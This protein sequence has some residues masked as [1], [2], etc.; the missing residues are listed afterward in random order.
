M[1][2]HLTRCTPFLTLNSIMKRLE[3]LFAPAVALAI[4]A[5]LLKLAY[6]PPL[7]GSLL[8]VLLLAACYGYFRFFR[9]LRVPLVLF[10]LL[11]VAMEVDLLGNFFHM[12]GR[13][14]GPVQY[15]EF[16]HMMTSALTVPIFVWL[17]RG[18]ILRF[19]HRLPLGLVATLAVAISF[20]GAALYEIIEL[21][22]EKYFGG[23]R[24]WGPYDTPNDLQ[25]DLLGKI[26]GAVI[27]VLVLGRFFSA[28]STDLSQSDR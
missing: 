18:F 10:A 6:M 22:D 25:W 14:F 20:S 4:A 16:S 19:D 11:F 28:P 17:L 3:W 1:N 24:I 9:G 23:K 21:W 7:F 13:P 26:A 27:M 12:Y 15:D 2:G 5:Y 8:G